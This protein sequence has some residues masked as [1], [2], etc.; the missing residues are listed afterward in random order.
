MT[1]SVN[2]QSV[3]ASISGNV[4]Q[5]IRSA[6]VF[7]SVGERRGGLSLALTVSI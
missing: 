7:V 4:E 3:R 6:S 5:A 2:G 1:G